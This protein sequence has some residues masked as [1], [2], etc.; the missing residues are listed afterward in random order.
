MKKFIK[1]T[2]LLIIPLLVLGSMMTA[3]ESDDEAMGGGQPRIDYVRVTNPAAGDSL[4]VGAPLGN[5]IAIVGQNLGG[6]K[7]LWF[8]DQKAVLE[9]TYVTNKTILV[10]VPNRAPGVVKNEMIL[11]FANGDTL[12]HPFEVTISAPLVLAMENEYAPIGTT[13][14]VAGD[15]FFEPM[16]VTFTGGAEAEV[17]F[18]NQNEINVTVPE[19]A[20]PGPVTFASS[21]G[22]TVSNFH[23]KDQ[24]NI[25]LDYD[26]LTAAGSWRPGPIASENGIDG[27]YLKLGGELAANERI[28]DNFASQFWGHTRFETERNL[29]DGY[30]EDLVLKFEARAKNWYGSYFQITWAPWSNAGNQEYWANLNGRGLWR[31]WEE[32]DAP[33]DTDGE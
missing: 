23:Y 16:T 4:L 9:P 19:G 14:K 5:L 1:N 27:N 12:I 18:V 17:E 32:N 22:T 2:W 26:E 11:V 8:N 15:F 6:T 28:E 7:H 13:T 29:F 3:C 10:N 24:R 30:P 25:I 21:F 20:L 33:F 31:P